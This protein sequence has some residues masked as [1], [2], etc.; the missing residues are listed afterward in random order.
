MTRNDPNSWQSPW[1]C[2]DDEPALAEW[3]PACGD[4][5]G[6]A[7]V[8]RA[9]GHVEV[10]QLTRAW[11]ARAADGEDGTASQEG[12]GGGL[13]LGVGDEPDGVVDALRLAPGIQVRDGEATVGPQ[14]DGHP[15]PARP[16]RPDQALEDGDRAAGAVGSPAK[17]ADRCW[18]TFPW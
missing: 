3:G 9:A 15:R 6:D 8:E 17:D 13:Q 1:Q 2:P 5:L 4:H 18:T 12:R 11:V 10:L 14:L 7:F 16:Q